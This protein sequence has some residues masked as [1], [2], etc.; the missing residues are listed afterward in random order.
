MDPP[1][2]CEVTRVI[3][4]RLAREIRGELRYKISMTTVASRRDKRA[5]IELLR[6][7]LEEER[8]QALQRGDA[9]AEQVQEIERQ[10][11]MYRFLP[12]SELGVDD[13]ICPAALVELELEGSAVRSLYLVVPRAG[14]LV[15]RF[16]GQPVQ[17]VSPQSPIG[18]A[19][20]G[21][22]L[23][24]QIELGVRGGNVR[25]YRVVAIE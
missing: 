1:F 2:R 5:L 18:E 19:I 9:D 15:T 11:L 17:V 12:V 23:G 20:L 14:G 24:D 8:D 21:R 16:E 7:H 6:T 22:R 10:I 13:V 4:A 3:F 25:R